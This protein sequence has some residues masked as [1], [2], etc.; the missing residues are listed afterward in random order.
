M[1]WKARFLYQ[2]EEDENFLLGNEEECRVSIDDRVDRE[3]RKGCFDDP[4]FQI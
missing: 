4:Y 1:R 2:F 3:K